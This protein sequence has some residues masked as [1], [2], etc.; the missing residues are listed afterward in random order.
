MTLESHS[1]KITI[2]DVE[3]NVNEL[4][5]QGEQEGA[6]VWYTE[7]GDGVGLFFYDMVPDLPNNLEDKSLLTLFYQELLNDAAGKV[8][9]LDVVALDNVRAVKLLI[10]V[11]QSPSGFTYVISYTIPYKTFS[12]VLKGQC[13]EHGDTGIKETILVSRILKA[14]GSIENFNADSPDYDEEFP[15][16]PVARARSIAEIISRGIKISETVK[17]HESFG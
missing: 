11:P 2:N 7:Y 12:F 1:N 15:E 17:Q 9:E 14:H 8:V 13:E 6:K 16:H 4:S 3:L 10:K 5:Y